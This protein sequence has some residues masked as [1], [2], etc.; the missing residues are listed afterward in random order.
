MSESTLETI[1]IAGDPDYQ[2]ELEKMR[3]LLN[4]E[5]GI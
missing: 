1:N 4:D 5:I 2:N 3:L